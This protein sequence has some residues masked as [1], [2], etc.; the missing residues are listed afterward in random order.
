[1]PWGS[2]PT[3]HVLGPS[4]NP[5]DPE[6]VSPQDNEAKIALLTVAVDHMLDRCEKRMRGSSTSG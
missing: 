3:D 5:A 4:S 1:M 6:L 2:P